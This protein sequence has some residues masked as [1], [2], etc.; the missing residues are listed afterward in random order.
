MGFI[1]MTLARGSHLEY[2]TSPVNTVRPCLK[3][4]NKIKNK[5]KRA[6]TILPEEPNLVSNTISDNSLPIILVP[7]DPVSCS[8]LVGAPIYT[9]V[10]AHTD[11]HSYIQKG[12]MT[13]RTTT[14][15]NV[16]V[17]GALCSC[18]VGLW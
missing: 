3:K 10:H 11:I 12:Q 1:P 15:S 17:R 2:K 14:K 16:E 18:G 4:Q 9:Y 13:I 5:Q 8:D 6:C 7:G